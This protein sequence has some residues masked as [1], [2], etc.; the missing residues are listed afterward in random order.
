MYSCNSLYHMVLEN[1]RFSILLL[2]NGQHS[3]LL[4][5]ARQQD[6]VTQLREIQ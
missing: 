2:L 4:N 1:S 6:V 3:W 5:F